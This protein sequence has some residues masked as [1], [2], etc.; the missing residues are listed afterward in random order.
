MKWFKKKKKQNEEAGYFF[1]H[2][3]IAIQ[4]SDIELFPDRKTVFANIAKLHKEVLFPLCSIKMSLLN[5]DWTFRAHFIYVYR[6]PEENLTYS[7]YYTPYCGDYSLGFDLIG[8]KYDLQAKLEMLTISEQ[9]KKYQQKAEK[10]YQYFVQDYQN[11]GLDNILSN[12]EN[13]NFL[14][15]RFGKQPIWVQKDETP[16][17]LDGKPLMF[18]GQVRVLD[19]IGE[20]QYLYLFYSPQYQYFVQREQ[21]S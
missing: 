10:K 15:K 16:I 8:E 21:Y 17:D 5:P 13:F 6:E 12:Q 9:Y 4:S 20:E 14:I 3:G 11:N 18:V 7:R 1:Q 19:F 2:D